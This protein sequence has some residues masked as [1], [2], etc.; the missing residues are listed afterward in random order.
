[1]HINNL[2]PRKEK[3]ERLKDSRNV[4]AKRKIKGRGGGGEDVRDMSFLGGKGITFL[5]GS[6]AL[7]ACPSNKDRMKVKTLGWQ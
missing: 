3:T 4:E 7:P 6:Q 2:K 1:L 5:E